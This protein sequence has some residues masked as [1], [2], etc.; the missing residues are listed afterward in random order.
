[1]CEQDPSKAFE[2]IM[3]STMRNPQH[4]QNAMKRIIKKLQDKIQRGE[5]R[6]ED[7][8][9]EAEEMM[10]EFSENPAFVEMMES[11][12]KT[13]SFEDP[14]AAKAAGQD[15]SARLALVRNRLRQKQAQKDA[16]RA[17][18]FVNPVQV[19]AASEAAAASMAAQL[20]AEDFD[21]IAVKPTGK[22]GKKQ[23]KK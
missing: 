4:L 8:A 12:R 16:A 19:N 11:M 14:E 17:N 3:Q 7:L 22:A 18:T 2:V 6:P 13:F 15:Q 21:S 5:F 9:A 10:K 23:A 20:E 1:M